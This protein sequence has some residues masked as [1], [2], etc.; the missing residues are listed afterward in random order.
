[1]KSLFSDVTISRSIFKLILPLILISPIASKA[2]DYDWKI[3]GIYALNQSS[4]LH[5][6]SSYGIKVDRYD[7]DVFSTSARLEFGDGYFRCSSNFFFP[8]VGMNFYNADLFF[9]LAE[10]SAFSGHIN[11]NRDF[12][13]SPELSILDLVYYSDELLLNE[14]EDIDY[15]ESNFF[16]GSSLGVNLSYNISDLIDFN[17]YV[18][19]LYLWQQKHTTINNGFRLGFKF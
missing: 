9:E 7:S 12:T 15:L 11:I 14:T 1:M 13:I 3:A 2:Q 17:V 16:T 4:K 5:T 6:F 10:Y 8:I 18:D 19:A